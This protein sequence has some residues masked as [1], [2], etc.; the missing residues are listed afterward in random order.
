LFK[1]TS[2]CINPAPFADYI[3]NYLP[4]L[5]KHTVP[6]KSLFETFYEPKMFERFDTDSKDL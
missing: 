4:F 2:L 3:Q 6:P 5:V 1:T